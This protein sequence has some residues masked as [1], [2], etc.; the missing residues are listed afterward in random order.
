MRSIVFVA[1][2]SLTA[3]AW[4]QATWSTDE[5]SVSTDNMTDVAIVN[6]SVE[7][8]GL[9]AAISNPASASNF[10]PFKFDLELLPSR[11][12]CSKGKT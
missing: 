5:F 1:L 2:L 10:P 3:T 7:V 11:A 6:G 8:L 4:S 9:P 12:T